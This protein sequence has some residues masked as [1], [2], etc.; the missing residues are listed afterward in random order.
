[1][2]TQNNPSKSV[3][4]SPLGR[5][6]G[7]GSAAHGAGTWKLERVTSVILLPLSLWFVYVVLHLAHADQDTVRA[8]IGQPWN[9]VLF[10]LLLA[11]MFPHI[12]LG[13]RSIVEDY[14]RGDVAKFLLLTL[15][16]AGCVILALLGA[17]SVL[18]LAI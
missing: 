7:L 9:A 6:R 12:A 3:M 2:S 15:I 10:L 13:L 11:T 17:I 14:I 4:R 1:M 8:F 5:A 16:N 18:K